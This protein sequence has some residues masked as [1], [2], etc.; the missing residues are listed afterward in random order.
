ME[1]VES[2]DLSRHLAFEVGGVE[3][4]NGPDPTPAREQRFPKVLQTNPIR[5]EHSNARDNC[6]MAS[7]H[8][9]HPPPS[10][11]TNHVSRKE[12]RAAVTGL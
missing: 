8:F 11:G 2:L 12:S 5:S 9:L 10:L 7:S 1:G 6:S 4:R 3:K